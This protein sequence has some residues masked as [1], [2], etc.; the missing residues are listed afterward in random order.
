MWSI[1]LQGPEPGVLSHSALWQKQLP[2]SFRSPFYCEG[3]LGFFSY[4]KKKYGIFFLA[5]QSFSRHIF[6]VRIPNTKAKSLYQ[7]IGTMLKVRERVQFKKKFFL[8]EVIWITVLH[9]F[10]DTTFPTLQNTSIRR[11][12]RFEIKIVSKPHFWALWNSCKSTGWL[13]KTFSR[14][15]HKRSEIKNSISPWIAR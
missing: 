6:C 7:A 8:K 1:F 14:T 10:Q 12:K 2:T 9:M 11:R 4:K 13:E 15:L 5:V 3:D